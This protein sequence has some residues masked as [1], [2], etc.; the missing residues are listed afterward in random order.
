VVN[1]HNDLSTQREKV[2]ASALEK[3]T[4]QGEKH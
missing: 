2:E 4:K 3:L 1:S